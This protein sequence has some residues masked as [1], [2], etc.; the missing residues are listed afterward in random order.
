MLIKIIPVKIIT[1]IERNDCYSFSKI[2]IKK[3]IDII[4]TIIYPY[5]KKIFFYFIQ[6]YFNM[7]LMSVSNE[8]YEKINNTTITF[9]NNM[10]FKLLNK[11]S[12]ILEKFL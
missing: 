10:F 8:I 2:L 5:L 12:I 6:K 1:N 9:L 4:S 7:T 11:I 3:S